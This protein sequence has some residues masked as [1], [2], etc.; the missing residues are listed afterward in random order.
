MPPAAL[1]GGTVSGNL[2][3][4]STRAGRSPAVLL[5]MT[6]DERLSCRVVAHKSATIFTT[7]RDVM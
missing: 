1:R 6:T 3:S 2:T 4:T 7:P 5:G